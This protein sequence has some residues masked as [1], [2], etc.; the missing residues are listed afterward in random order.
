[1]KGS[2]LTEDTFTVSKSVSNL[3]SSE[4]YTDLILRADLVYKIN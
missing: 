1:M 4:L 3:L 2:E